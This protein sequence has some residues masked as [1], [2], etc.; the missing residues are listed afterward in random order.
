MLKDLCRDIFFVAE[1][2]INHD[3]DKN[4]IKYMIDADAAQVT[5]TLSVC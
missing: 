3:G 2:G 5:V 1:L 4:K